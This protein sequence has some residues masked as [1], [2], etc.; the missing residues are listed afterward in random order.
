MEEYNRWTQGDR[1]NIHIV[2]KPGGDSSMN[3]GWEEKQVN[4]KVVKKIP[5]EISEKIEKVDQV[6]QD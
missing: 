5:D 2:Q 3:L 4:P 6:Q 1:N